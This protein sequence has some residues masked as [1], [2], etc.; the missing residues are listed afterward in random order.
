[1]TPFAAPTEN[2]IQRVVDMV[3]NAVQPVR[4][5]LFGSAARG[6]LRD[7]S[8]LDVMVVMPESVDTLRVAQKLHRSMFEIPDV[9]RRVSVDFVVTTPSRYDRGQHS[10]ASV[11]GDVARDGRELYA[12]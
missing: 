7:G 3:V 11:F 1:M 9:A 6:E 2:D 10:S 5:V 12:A 4:I 8:D